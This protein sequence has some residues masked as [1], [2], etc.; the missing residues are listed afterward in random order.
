MG[1]PRSAGARELAS[2]AG[3]RYCFDEEALRGRI[4]YVNRH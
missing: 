1:D 4:D 3:K 2:R